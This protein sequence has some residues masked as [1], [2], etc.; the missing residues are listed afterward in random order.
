MSKN[1]KT[2]NEIDDYIATFSDEER[3]EY[4]VAEAA[5]D[6]ACMLYH[7]RQERGL[8]QQEAAKRAGLHQ[9]A[10]SR[11]EKAAS[12]IQL[13]TLQRYLSALGYDIEISVRDSRTGKVA[14]R[15]V[16]N[17]AEGGKLSLV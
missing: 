17:V 9:Q 6:F 8:S 7:L 1:T 4:E 11:L 3:K 13:G 5:L 14:G 12:N 2:Y 16:G 10:I 15:V